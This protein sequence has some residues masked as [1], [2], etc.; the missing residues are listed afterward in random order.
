MAGGGD[1]Q[2]PM[3]LS[4]GAARVIKAGVRRLLESAASMGAA[5][6]RAGRLAVWSRRARIEAAWDSVIGGSETDV[7]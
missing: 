2:I 6:S 5:T 4:L 3:D 1:Q 7:A